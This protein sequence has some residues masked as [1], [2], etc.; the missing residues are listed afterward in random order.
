MTLVARSLDGA[1]A[2]AE[3]QHKIHL[4]LWDQE[5]E[6]PDGVRPPVRCGRRL[7]SVRW[8]QED[9]RVSEGAGPQYHKGNSGKGYTTRQPS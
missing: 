3:S 7:W 1:R 5:E 8:D 9:E 4:W 6:E 2:A